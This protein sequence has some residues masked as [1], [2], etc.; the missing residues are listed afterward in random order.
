MNP[1]LDEEPLLSSSLHFFTCLFQNAL[2]S[3]SVDE[4]HT[5]ALAVLVVLTA[6]DVYD[7]KLSGDPSCSWFARD[8]PVD[9]MTHFERNLPLDE[10]C[11][12]LL[13]SC[14]D[15]SVELLDFSA[16]KIETI[17]LGIAPK[18]VTFL[19]VSQSLAPQPLFYV[20]ND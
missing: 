6:R 5:R 12:R 4:S 17:R 19:R 10:T 2:S 11:W 7:G 8:S 18:C 9:V 1:L 20:P 15:V 13:G 16:Q 3:S 14:C